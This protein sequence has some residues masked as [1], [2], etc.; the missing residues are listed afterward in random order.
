MVNNKGGG[1]ITYVVALYAPPAR[2]KNIAEYLSNVLVQ[3]KEQSK[4]PVAFIKGN[5]RAFLVKQTTYESMELLKVKVVVS[6]L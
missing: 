2:P 4:F 6:Q 3:S 5:M 1:V